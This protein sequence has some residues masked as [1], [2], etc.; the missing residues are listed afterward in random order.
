MNKLFVILL[1]ALLSLPISIWA[2]DGNVLEPIP[3]FDI[4]GEDSQTED[5]TPI[6][7][8]DEDNLE[9]TDSDSRTNYN[10]NDKKVSNIPYKQP[11]SKKKIALKFLAAMGGVALSS[12]I[13]YIL[14]SVYNRIRDGLIPSAKTSENETPLETPDNLESA[15]KTFLDKTDWK[16]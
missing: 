5:L 7:Q 15:V 10:S 2:A 3:A 8:I 13:I 14:L 9:A 1:T 11:V 12:I 6:N 16:N 4:V